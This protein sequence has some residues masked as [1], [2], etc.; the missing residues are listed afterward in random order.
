[1]PRI[2][3]PKDWK[4]RATRAL[5]NLKKPGV[6]AACFWCGHPY[7]RGEY[8]PEAESAHLLKCTEYPQDAKR[9]MQKQNDTKPKTRTRGRHHLPRR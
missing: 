2:R 8:G 6:G 3:L 9:R 5:R 7:R 4:H 1:M